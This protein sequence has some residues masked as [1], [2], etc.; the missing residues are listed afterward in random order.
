MKVGNGQ[1]AKMYQ[2]VSWDPFLLEQT[3]WPHLMATGDVRKNAINYW[4]LGLG[5]PEPPRMQSTYCAPVIAWGAKHSYSGKVVLLLLGMGHNWGAI[6][7]HR[8]NWKMA[9]FQAGELSLVSRCIQILVDPKRA[10]VTPAGGSCMD[11]PGGSR[12]LNLWGV[13][14]TILGISLLVMSWM[15]NIRKIWWDVASISYINPESNTWQTEIRAFNMTSI[16]MSAHVVVALGA[17]V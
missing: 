13:S 7:R 10:R 8:Q 4:H 9:I 17:F 14:T 2:H 5:H 1:P 16:G 12:D 3:C 6:R 15:M 11:P